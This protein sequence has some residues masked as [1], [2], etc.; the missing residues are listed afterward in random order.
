M[1]AMAVTTVLL[2]NR[3]LKAEDRM[4]RNQAGYILAANV[5]MG[6]LSVH[7]FFPLY[8]IPQY[9]LGNIAVIFYLLLVGLA[10]RRT[11]FMDFGTILRKGLI[12]S[13][14]TFLLTAVYLALILFLEGLVRIYLLPE[15]LFI[16][17]IP[18][19]VVAFMF[20]G[21]RD[22]VQ[23]R[24]DAFFGRG[25]RTDLLSSFSRATRDSPS[26]PEM[27]R[28]FCRTVESALGPTRLAF[29]S[30]DPE[31]GHWREEHHVG[32]EAES[33]DCLRYGLLSEAVGERGDVVKI[34]SRPEGSRE[35]GDIREILARM[36]FVLLVPLNG[37]TG[38]AGAVL[39]GEKDTGGSYTDEDLSFMAALSG[40]AAALLEAREY[41]E[42]WKREEKFTA[43]GRASATISHELRNPLNIIQGAVAYLDSRYSGEDVSRFTGIIGEEV[44]RTS[45]FIDRFLSASR[46]PAARRIRVEV[47]D[48]VRRF[49]GEWR[50]AFPGSRLSLDLPGE[51]VWTE[52][53]PTLLRQLLDNLC[54]NALEAMPDGGEITIAVGEAMPSGAG[55]PRRPSAGMIAVTVSDQG[56]GIG[57]GSKEAIF[58]PFYTTKEGGSGLGLCVVDSVVRAHGGYMDVDSAEGGGASFRICLPTGR[59]DH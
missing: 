32:L 24:L 51:E 4:T 25:R 37:R 19:L 45:R 23:S 43:L 39:M 41:Y 12:Y 1:S 2:V 20:R 3:F 6:I 26:R 50:G 49:A 10:V 30:L 9:P 22:R 59:N 7:N 54:R 42:R 40:Q 44:D 34:N 27:A 56:P 29:Y 35:E 52:W 21:V 58:D 38:L 46:I 28:F 47:G 16:P 11:S 14:A 5:L 8:G 13:L 15:S 36:G 31:T 33:P 53:D 18:A 57:E 55:G 48:L 17:L